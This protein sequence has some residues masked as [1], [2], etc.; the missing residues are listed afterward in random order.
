MM[1]ISMKIDLFKYND[2]K[3]KFVLIVCIEVLFFFK[4]FFKSI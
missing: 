1:K 2:L 3:V 4:N